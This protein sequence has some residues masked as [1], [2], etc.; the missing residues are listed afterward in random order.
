MLFYDL[1]SFLFSYT[2]EEE[3][4][5]SSYLSVLIFSV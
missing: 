3:D 1:L 4:G 5:V 2:K